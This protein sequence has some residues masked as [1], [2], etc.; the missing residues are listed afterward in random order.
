MA[1]YT[2]ACALRY[3]LHKHH[4][5]TNYP[6]I[7]L[8]TAS[9]A[10]TCCSHD[11]TKGSRLSGN[12]TAKQNWPSLI[13]TGS[14]HAKSRG[15]IILCTCWPLTGLL[16][17]C[18]AQHLRTPHVRQNAPAHHQA[19]SHTASYTQQLRTVTLGIVDITLRTLLQGS[20]LLRR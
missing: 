6:S 17:A 13:Q 16:Y 20:D 11:L 14:L 18:P 7:A 10:R 12:A 1:G 19:I 8:Q 3:V 5:C 9:S 4:L 2:T 15:A